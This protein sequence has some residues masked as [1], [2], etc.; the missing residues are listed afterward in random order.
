VVRNIMERK[1]EQGALESKA[2]ELL[3]R[4]KMPLSVGYVAFHLKITW[5]TARGLLLKMSLG[6]KIRALETSKGYMFV[7]KENN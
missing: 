3:E 7:A 6:G 5:Q 2:V 1:A 4:K